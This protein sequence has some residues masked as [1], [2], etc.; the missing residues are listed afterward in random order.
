MVKEIDST[1]LE[2]Q[3]TSGREMYLLDIRSATEVVRGV[4]PMS[5]HLPMHLLP[6]RMREFP[7]DKDIVLYC[8]SGQRSHHACRHL[9]QQGFNNVIN[10]RGGILDWSRSGFEVIA[11]A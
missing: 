11:A 8:H 6:L 2:S 3:L 7:A 9:M 1:E 4:L 10:L 5:Q